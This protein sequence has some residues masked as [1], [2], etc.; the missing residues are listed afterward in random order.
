MKTKL[1][2]LKDIEHDGKSLKAGDI[3]LVPN[4]LAKSWLFDGVAERVQ[5]DGVEDVSGQV[6]S[7]VDEAFKAL[8][9][10]NKIKKAVGDISVKHEEIDPSWGYG[11]PLVAG[12][13]RSKGA[14]LAN[15]AAFMQDVCKAAVDGVPE[16][17]KKAMDIGAKAAQTPGQVIGNDPDGGFAVPTETRI[18]LDGATVEAS[19]IRQ[20]ATVVP[21][22]TKSLDLT[23]IKDYD[24]SSG[25]VSGAAIA[26]WG[27]ENGALTS[28]KIQFENRKLDLQPLTALA[29]L[30][31]QA[32]KFS[33]ITGGLL[34]QEMGKAISFA[35]EGAFLTDG[36]GA[37]M[38]LAIMKAAN[39]IEVAR[40]TSSAIVFADIIAM[41]ARLRV[42]NEGAVMWYA[43]RTCLPQLAALN[44]AVGTAGAPIW[45]PNNDATRGI[46]GTLYG[47]PLTWSE[48]PEALGTAGDI[49]LGDF[50]QYL[51][52]DHVEGPESASSMHV[53]F[54]EAQELFRIIKYVDGQVDGKTVYTPKHGDTLAPF[55]NLSA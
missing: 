48:Y 7:A 51:I 14:R 35:E 44:L 36:T 38:P 41:I 27:Q 23:R 40:N 20:R 29:A 13:K 54:I 34:L 37:G 53:K 25:Y 49:V 18:D 1:K 39:K 17:L 33:P 47:Y 46:P 24:H 9:I 11:A 45:I 16:R 28:S 50:S 19:H 2:I 31:H 32:M 55:V 42:K 26:Y 52:G 12:Q 4:E 22:G 5:D 21:M 8:E 10:D 3:C 30:S 6:K 43:N 15:A